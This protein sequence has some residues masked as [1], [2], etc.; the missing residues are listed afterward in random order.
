VG[1]VRGGGFVCEGWWEN[2]SVYT[3]VSLVRDW[4]LSVTDKKNIPKGKIEA[5][6]MP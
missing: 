5:V 6:A 3:K 2:I 1:I 4:I